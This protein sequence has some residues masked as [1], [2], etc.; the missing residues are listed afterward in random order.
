MPKLIKPTPG[1][2]IIISIVG[3]KGGTLKT[4]T[5]AT[6]A[7]VLADRGY[8]ATLV[9]LDPQ[10]SLT[11]RCG[12]ERPS[13]DPLTE[14]PVRVRYWLP[15]DP[16]GVRTEA[17][18][19]GMVTLLRGGRQLAAATHHEIAAQIRRANT[20]E[21]APHFVVIDT[22]PALTSTTQEAMRAAGIIVVP[23]DPTREGLD[24]LADVILL[25]EAMGLTCPVRAVLSKVIYLLHDQNDLA[26]RQLDSL[27][28]YTLIPGLRAVTE[29]PFTKAGA[30]SSSFE[31]PATVTAADDRVSVAYRKLVTE[32]GRTLG[33]K[34][35]HHRSRPSHEAP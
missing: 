6:L 29:I 8:R 33:L 34:L 22:P 24:G 16:S 7:H 4:A 27:T 17:R 13:G 3:S 30:E 11:L 31:L 14:P 18:V 25:Q 2:P 20:G 9:D 10:G 35:R 15:A 32:L 23:T 26:R 5:A 12:F 19:A 28:P 21:P 1:A